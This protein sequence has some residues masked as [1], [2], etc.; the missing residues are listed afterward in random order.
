M[1]FPHFVS[2]GHPNQ[3]A[4]G[5]GSGMC[6]RL[7]QKIHSGGNQIILG[8]GFKYFWFH[9]YLGKISNLT[10]IFQMGWNHQLALEI[11]RTIFFNFHE[12]S[13][14]FPT[15][16]GWRSYKTPRYWDVHGT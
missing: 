10:H 8:D 3:I 11:L 6:F 9:S 7:P 2:K 15:L 5:V 4:G 16:A 13:K 12:D 14:R 1:R